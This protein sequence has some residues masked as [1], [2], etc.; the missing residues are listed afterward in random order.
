MNTG[1]GVPGEGA[2]L[3]VMDV[4]R[5]RLRRIR[6]E[7]WVRERTRDGHR[8]GVVARPVGDSDRPPGAS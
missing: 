4:E 1:G 6:Y 8:S 5:G 7:Q 3:Y 2:T